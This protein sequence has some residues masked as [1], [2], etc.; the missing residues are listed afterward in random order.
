[1]FNLKHDTKA[2]ALYL[3][4]DDSRIIE[5][6]EVSPGVILDYNESNGIEMHHISKR[7]AKLDLSDVKIESVWHQTKDRR[8]RSVTCSPL[9]R[10]EGGEA[11]GTGTE[12][13]RGMPAEAGSPEQP[14]PQHAKGMIL[15]IGQAVSGG[16]MCH[17][18]RKTLAVCRMCHL[19][20]QDG[21]PNPRTQK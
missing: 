15:E 17:S 14:K 10:S 7:S 12:R 13:Q 21:S 4:L 20:A 16:S 1:M 9:S 18:Q 3:R 11:R 5:S 2:D 19:N 8:G 6:E